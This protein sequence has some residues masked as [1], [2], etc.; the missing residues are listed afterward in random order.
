MASAQG[1][2]P[3]QNPAD[4]GRPD[5]ATQTI[6][7]LT[8]QDRAAEGLGPLAWD[9]ALAT[10]AAVHTVAMVHAEVLSHQLPGEADVAGR[11]AAAGAHFRAVAENIAYGPSAA[12]IE[13]QWMHSAPHRANILDP[14][15]DRIGISIVAGAGTLWAAEDFAAGTPALSLAAIEQTVEQELQSRSRVRAAAEG[16]EEKAAARAACPQF[17]G[18][19]GARA[20]FVVRWES[21]DLHAVPQPL[22]DAL[23]SGQYTVAAV[24]AC[25]AA[26]TRNQAFTAYRVAVLLF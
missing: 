23:G 16:S 10:A 17:D 5:A 9:P 15:M 26:N 4:A 6:L 12:A 18:T 14:R 13:Q 7:D 21:S 8:N 25:P 1:L 20:R 19:A 24:G 3:L 11:A 22:A 2:L